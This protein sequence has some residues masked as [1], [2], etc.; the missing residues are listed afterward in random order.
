VL[1]DEKANSSEMNP[2]AKNKVIY[3]MP[4]QVNVDLGG[5]MRLG[6]Y[7]ASVNK[8]SLSYIAYGTTKIIERHRHRYE[9]NN[10]YRALLENAGL[11]IEVLEPEAPNSFVFNSIIKAN[12]G[13]KL[14]IYRVLSL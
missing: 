9:F 2:D 6:D 8:K 1:G 11:I 3:I 14:P 10:D 7:Q 5:S 13:Q 12:P 4:D